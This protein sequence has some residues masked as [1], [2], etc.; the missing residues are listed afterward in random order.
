MKDAMQERYDSVKAE[1]EKA[2]KDM[3]TGEHGIMSIDSLRPEELAAGKLIFDMVIYKE[4]RDQDLQRLIS[5]RVLLGAFLATI[6]HQKA[7]MSRVNQDKSRAQPRA[8]IELLYAWLDQNISKYYKRL[9]DCAEDAVKQIPKLGMK[10]GTVKRH[11]T[12]YRNKKDWRPVKQK[13]NRRKKR[14]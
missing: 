6:D 11:I 12:A 5:H 8:R 7:V 13:I 3:A 1:L 2:N 4:G 10:P 14:Q 9:E